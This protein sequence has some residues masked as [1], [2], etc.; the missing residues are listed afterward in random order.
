[1]KTN[2]NKFYNKIKESKNEKDIIIIFDN[3]INEIINKSIYFGIEK[4]EIIKICKN[5]KKENNFEWTKK[6]AKKFGNILK[7]IKNCEYYI[8]IYNKIKEKQ[9]LSGYFLYLNLLEGETIFN[10][11]IKIVKIS[12]VNKYICILDVNGNIYT[13]GEGKFGQLGHGLDIIELNNFKKIDN[14]PNMKEISCGFAFVLAVTNDNKL[15]SWGC[16]DDGR[17]GNGSDG[18]LYYP[19]KV[20]TNVQVHNVYAGSVH[21]CLIDTSNELYSFGDSLYNGLGLTINT[22]EPTKIKSLEGIYFNCLSIGHGSY[23]TL[24]LTFYG[25]VYGWGHN[26]LGQ[27]G[28]PANINNN[29]NIEFKSRIFDIICV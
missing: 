21:G 28:L 29:I 6:I 18:C 3:I 24:G 8:D 2:I 9:K 15:F 4:K 11:K 10:N 14:I 5:K 17:L 25:Q 12:T 16:G 13:Q 27:L 1:M 22:Y 19:K 20:L 7:L 23:H 26:R